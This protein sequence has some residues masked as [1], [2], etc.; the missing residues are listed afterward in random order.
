[1]LGGPQAGGSLP[2][3]ASQELVFQTCAT[4]PLF[5]FFSFLP[6]QGALWPSA[7]KGL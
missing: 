3:L 7:T 4:T 1:M 2:V 5:L 6:I